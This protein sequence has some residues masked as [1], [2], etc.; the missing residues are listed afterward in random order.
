MTTIARGARPWS[1]PRFKVSQLA[2]GQVLAYNGKAFVNASAALSLL[3]DTDFSA[4][5]SVSVDGVFTATHQNYRIVVVGQTSTTATVELRL[6]AAG[7]DDAGASDY[8]Y[9]RL[10]QEADNSATLLEGDPAYTGIVLVNAQTGELDFH[11]A[12]DVFRPAA[13]ARTFVA[14][15]AVA[16]PGAAS[17]TKVGV[18][19]GQ[20]AATDAFDGFT[21]LPSTGTFTGS[22]RTYGYGGA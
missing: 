7:A 20:R 12:V 9:A 21:L 22:V 14:G 6:R 18:V 2:S 10:S 17:T 5:A 1:I 11:A 3:D 16:W 19:G 4:A 15:V 8:A 13:T